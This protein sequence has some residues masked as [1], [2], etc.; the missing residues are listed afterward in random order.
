MKER[1]AC[2]GAVCVPESY[3]TQTAGTMK[4][5]TTS[6]SLIA[7]ESRAGIK[8]DVADQH[9]QKP[10]KKGENWMLAAVKRRRV[11]SVASILRSSR[12]TG[13]SFTL[14]IDL[15]PQIHMILDESAVKAQLVSNDEP[16]FA[17]IFQDTIVQMNQRHSMALDSPLES[18]T[19]SLSFNLVIVLHYHYL[20]V[21]VCIMAMNI[22]NT[23]NWDG[24]NPHGA[25]MLNEAY[26]E[27]FIVSIFINLGNPLALLSRRWA[28]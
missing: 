14:D 9:K 12:R 27:I 7:S 22:I 11:I 16:L 28:H 3:A 18:P 2:A 13:R 21:P 20:I 25:I 1:G 17:V 26:I 10:L 15:S 4:S 5:K 24:Q 8:K 23:K 19:I 6:E